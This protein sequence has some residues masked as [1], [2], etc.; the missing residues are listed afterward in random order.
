MVVNFLNRRNRA[1]ERVFEILDAKFRLFDG[2][3]GAS[4]EVLG[5]LESVST[6]SAVSP[7]YQ[8]CRS[9]EEIKDAFDTLQREL[10]EQIQARMTST[11][12]VLTENFD[13][14]SPPDFG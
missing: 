4:D 12:Q 14:M 13:G 11:R 6:S 9:P 3:F 7:V 1:D 8:T 5:A 2:V 10:D